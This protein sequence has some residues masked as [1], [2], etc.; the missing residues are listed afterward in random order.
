MI[1]R[2]LDCKSREARITTVNNDDALR[3][4]AA[5]LWSELNST[6]ITT[7]MIYYF[8]CRIDGVKTPKVNTTMEQVL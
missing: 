2:G 4:K 7:E 6:E 8:G 1:Y 3:R 5:A